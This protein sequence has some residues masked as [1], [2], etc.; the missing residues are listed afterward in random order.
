MIQKNKHRFEKMYKIA[1]WFP[2]LELRGFFVTTRGCGMLFSCI[3]L[4][5]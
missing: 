5:S 3:L 2:F 1:T 4:F